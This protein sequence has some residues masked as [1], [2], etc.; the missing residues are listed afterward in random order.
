MSG[1]RLMLV[2]KSETISDPTISVLPTA[3]HV[4]RRIKLIHEPARVNGEAQLY[5]KIEES[6]RNTLRAER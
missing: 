4:Q 6:A 5:L 3:D 1:A 2:A